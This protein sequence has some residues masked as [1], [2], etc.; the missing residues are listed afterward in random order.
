MRNPF[1]TLLVIS[2]FML[3]AALSGPALSEDTKSA[4]VDIENSEGMKKLKAMSDFLKS[5]KS[6]SFIVNSFYDEP[7]DDGLTIKRFVSHQIFLQHPDRL[8]FKAEFDDGTLRVGSFDGEKLTIALPAQKSY[9]EVPVSG[10]IDKMID[11]LH[12]EYDISLPI[13]DFLYSDIYAAQKE[14]IETADYVGPRQFFGQTFDQI[15]LSGPT[16]VWQLWIAS[17]NPLPTRFIAKY[18]REP[19]DPEY[20]ATFL[21]WQI[22]SVTVGDLV[23]EIPSDWK[24]VELGAKE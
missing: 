8:L 23:L 14:F 6:M 4:P 5:A 7:S 16:A 22:D 20:M 3:S 10:S 19:G 12:D 21:D 2:T 9:T 1:T 15:V 13:T 11:I 24:Q 18:F 17:D